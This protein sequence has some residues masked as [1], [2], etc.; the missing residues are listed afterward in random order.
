MNN[1]NITGPLRQ[2]YIN[3]AIFK[4]IFER[5][6]QSLIFVCKPH[7]RDEI[8]VDPYIYPDENIDQMEIENIEGGEDLV[9]DSETNSTSK[10]D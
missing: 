3:L 8:V 4:K 9:D 6:A 7:E 5:S 1:P 2:F 10:L